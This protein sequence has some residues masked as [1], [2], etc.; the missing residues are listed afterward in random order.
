MKRKTRKITINDK[1]YLWWYNLGQSC[2]V[3]QISPIN[4]KTSVVEINFDY[5]YKEHEYYDEYPQ[6]LVVS[7]DNIKKSVKITE[8][9]MVSILISALSDSAFISRKRFSYSGFDL[10]LRSGFKIISVEA[11]ILL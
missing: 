9:K 1:Q 8:P 7:K 5:E 3:I 11:G 2:A 10:L 4:D 6:Y